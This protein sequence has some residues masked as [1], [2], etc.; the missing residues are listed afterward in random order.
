MGAVKAPWWLA[1]GWALDSFL[2]LVTRE[3]ADS[4]ALILRRDHV[5]VREDLAEWDAHAADP[6]GTLRPW[7]VGEHLPEEV[8][9][10]WLRRRPDLPWAFQFMIDETDGGDWLYRRDR[11]IRR[12]LASLSGPTSSPACQVLAPEIQLLYKSKGLRPK[13][14]SDFA[15]VLPELDEPRRAWLRDALR[16]TSPDHPW[17]GAL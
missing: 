10:V 3:H 9:D 16:L 1:G 5:D 11:R 4:D 17:L 13:D 2:G 6:P 8:H 15:A 14:E 7:R 12:P